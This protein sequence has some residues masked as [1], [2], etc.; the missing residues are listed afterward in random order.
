MKRVIYAVI[1][2][3]AI[4]LVLLYAADWAILRVRESHNTAFSAVQ[5]EQFLLTPLK[6]NKAE[7]DY[8]GVTAQTCAR[9]I[10][11]HASD[12]PCWW[13]ERHKTQWEH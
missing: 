13:L 3:L 6:G 4:S 2:G 8:L 9:S 11:P 5:V 7:Y 12:P 1:R 10:F